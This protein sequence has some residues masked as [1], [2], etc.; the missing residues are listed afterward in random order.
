MGMP[1]FDNVNYSGKNLFILN[2]LQKSR[3]PLR[4]AVSCINTQI[5]LF[6][7]GQTS[8]STIQE[9]Y[10]EGAFTSDFCVPWYSNFPI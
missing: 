5:Y 1:F 9:E 6:T 8:Q 2:R 7:N 4:P 10:M 3:S